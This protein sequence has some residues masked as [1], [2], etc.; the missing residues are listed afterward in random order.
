M[1]CKDCGKTKEL[2]RHSETGSHKP[3]FI[4]LCIDCH[5]KR[6]GIKQKRFKRSQKGNTK[7]AK[8]TSRKKNKR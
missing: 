7:N 1:K 6:H 3:P 4:P 5:N 8:G 2:T